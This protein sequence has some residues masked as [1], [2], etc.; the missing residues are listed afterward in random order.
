MTRQRVTTPIASSLAAFTARSPSPPNELRAAATRHIVDVLGCGLAAAG[1]GAGGE[2]AAV[3][4][5][6][7]GRAAAS[8]IGSEQLVPA[9]AAA[10]ANGTRSHALDFDDTH[11][12]GICHVST[13]VAPAAIAVAE[14]EGCIGK[15]VLDAYL[16]GSE[17]AL[18]IAVAAAPGLY[19]RG[20]H[21]TSVCGAFGAAAAASRLLGLSSELTTQALGI[22]GSFASGLLEYLADGSGTKP[23]HA[24]WAAQAGVKAAALA[25]AGVTGPA[26]VIEGRFGLLRS[27]VDTH[28]DLRAVTEGL[29]ERWEIL[30]V[31]IKPYPACHFV[32]AVTW[33]VA[34]LAEQHRL[35]ADDVIEVEA[36][37]PAEGVPIVFEPVD[38][39]RSPATPHAAKFSAP[40]TIAHQL[41]HGEVSLSS[42]SESRISAPEVLAV[43][44]RI[45]GGAWQSGAPPSRFAGAVSVH[46]R[47]D[48][49]TLEVPH[50]PGSPGN[51]MSNASVMDKFRSNAR[52]AL[53]QMVVDDLLGSLLALDDHRDLKAFMA[54]MRAATSN[55]EGD[56]RRG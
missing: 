39:K 51:P 9:A 25:S 22:V 17:V 46:T 43:A 19:T 50:T 47:R 28:P 24:G 55:S 11:E 38:V 18:R 32:H 49:F 3:A 20:F 23:L 4:Q 15:E 10:F 26:S 2:A 7:G 36:R 52:R 48:T 14:A 8:V 33:A 5:A 41:V 16:L 54:P 37:I 45:Q 40:F 1:L 30:E 12:A 29:G 13:V 21:P 56:L 53:P 35:D 6:D 31:S 44:S 27:H 34:Q 42:F